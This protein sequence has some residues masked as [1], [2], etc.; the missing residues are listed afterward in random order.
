MHNCVSGLPHHLS[1]NTPDVCIRH[2]ELGE[3]CIC[4]A[5]ESSAS[6][7]WKVEAARCSGSEGEGVHR[8]GAAAAGK[9]REQGGASHCC[10][11]AQMEAIGSGGSKA[12][13][14]EDLP[15]ALGSSGLVTVWRIFFGC[16]MIPTGSMVNAHALSWWYYCDF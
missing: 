3:G 8:R 4:A 9:S 16:E 13:A 12:R 7:H 10:E 6:T 5:L 15:L 14:S 11:A 1:Q 2:S